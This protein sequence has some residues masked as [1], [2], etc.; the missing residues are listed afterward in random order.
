MIIAA[1]M[2]YSCRFLI[3]RGWNKCGSEF[4]RKFNKIINSG[5]KIN[6]G[7]EFLGKFNKQG[8]GINRGVGNS[9]KVE[10][11]GMSKPGITT[12]GQAGQVQCDNGPKTF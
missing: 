11:K 10:H 8:V 1:I 12:L 3:N 9:K 5:V 2:V 6:R 7:S 4:L